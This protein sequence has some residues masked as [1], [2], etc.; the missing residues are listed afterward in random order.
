MKKY[1]YSLLAAT[2]VMASFTACS[3]DDDNDGGGTPV[4]RY[5]RPCDVAKSDS[6]LLSGYLGDRIAIIGENL[7]GVRAVYFND[8]KAKLNPTFVTENSI[9]VSIPTGI[10]NVKQDL[11]KLFTSNDSCYHTFETIVPAPTVNS[12][13]CE[14]ISDGDIANIQGLYFIDEPSNPLKVVFQGDV[15][16]EIISH[17]INNIAVRVPA[18][19][20]KG[21][22][23]VS[24]VY[25][26]GVSSF[27]FRDDRNIILDFDTTFPDGGYHHGWHKGTGVSNVGGINGNYLIF[28]GEMTDSKWDDSNFGYERWTYRPTD[29]DF[30]DATALDKFVLKFE[31]NIPN[32]WSAAALQVIF[33]GSEEVWLNWQESPTGGNVSNAY[34]S[35]LT[36]PRALWMPWTETGS[37]TT[38]GWI[39]VTIPMTDF[40]YNKDGGKAEV[41]PAGHYSGI[42]LFVNGGGVKG[43]DCTPIFNIDNVR[44]VNAN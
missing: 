4:V 20:K 18:G 14:Y 17:D 41:K 13:T 24:S 5:V 39:T 16:G 35:S 9:I 8:Q 15:E 25:G 44:V 37:Y 38:N 27:H 26:T 6:L 33:T 3:D 1:L 32:V 21:T 31:V 29:P 2:F 11:I 10:P 12:M 28:S 34:V 40:K 36:H 22:L 23:Q 19:A 7:S 30:F 43:A 42:T